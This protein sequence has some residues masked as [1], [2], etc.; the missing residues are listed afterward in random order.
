MLYSPLA[1]GAPQSSAVGGKDATGTSQP[2][3]KEEATLSYPTQALAEGL[4][5]DVTVLVQVDADGKVIGAQIVSGL[6]AFHNAAL[7]AAKTLN[8]VPAQKDGQAIVS[9][10]RIRFHFA[11]PLEVQ[12]LPSDF[13]STK[14]MRPRIS[15]LA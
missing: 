9:S 7:D 5:G 13:S 15:E 12:Y 1:V 3:L 14:G 10:A 8:F 11:P 2:V 6:D 4:H